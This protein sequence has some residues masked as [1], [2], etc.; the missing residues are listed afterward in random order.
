MA[1]TSYSYLLALIPVI[2]LYWLA[3]MKWRRW[4][5]LAVSL[6]YYATWSAAH[7]ALPL[8]VCGVAYVCGRKM[9]QDKDAAGR[10]MWTGIAAVLAILSVFKYWPFVVENTNAAM[11]W[12][13]RQGLGP[14]YM[15]ALPLG[16]SFY[17]F[18]AV[19]YLLDTRQ[20]RTKQAR[21]SDLGLFVLFWPH[22]MAG[23][24]VR[25]REL[26]PQ[27]SKN[28]QFDTGH[29]LRGLDRL[30]IG[31]AQKNLLANNLAAFV[32]EGFLPQ[33]AASNSYLDNWFL[34]AAFGLQI[35]FDFASYSNMAI[36]VAQMMGITLPENFRFPY[37]AVSPPD[38]WGRWHM[39]LSRWI[40]D[41]LFFPVN[42]KYGGA[43]LPL[44]G[45]LIGIMA[46]VGLWHGAGWG[47]V[48]WGLMHGVY[49]VL[50]RIWEQVEE[51]HAWAKA[52]WA[53]WGWRVFTIVAVVAA[54][55]PF[56]AASLEQ[57]LTMLTAMATPASIRVSYSVNQYL[58]TM[59]IACYCV[60][61]PWL[62]ARLELPAKGEIRPQVAWLR[63][64][65]YAALLFIF[66]IFDDRDVQFIYFQF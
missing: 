19:S 63:P 34:A 14:G 2:G 54:W 16:I 24:I 26:V 15:L 45:S 29:L 36:G 40:R 28:L 31:L 44:Y 60:A 53:G 48:L 13:G 46:L 6:L 27:F 5:L 43:P 35:Y 17:T 20:G 47:Y 55:V 8:V 51:K 10:W 57:S 33:A 22:L 3:P 25:F 64:A 65:A 49:L 7:T 12:M 37:H 62:A 58:L 18:E 39:T 1:F 38:F 11:V 21:L 59:M 4:Y 52:W 9:E 56:R 61:E 32:D 41:Y 66:L 30:I 50:Y 42:A 23:P